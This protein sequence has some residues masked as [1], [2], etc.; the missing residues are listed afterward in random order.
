MTFIYRCP[1]RTSWLDINGH[2]NVLPYCQVFFDAY[3]LA[4]RD[5]G[6][7]P[8]YLEQGHSLF[9]GD[10]HITYVR[11]VRAGATL[12]VNTRIIDLDAKRFVF[13]QEMIE[14]HDGEL[15]ATAEHVQLNVGVASRKVEPFRADV[16][17][18]L[19]K[20]RQAQGESAARNVGRRSSLNAGAPAR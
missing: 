14:D 20:A 5:L 6:L 15:A 8:T 2:M 16:V 18:R 7:G 13:H 1:V 10:F 17:E 3:T 11:E 9:A 19:Q 4:C 12:T